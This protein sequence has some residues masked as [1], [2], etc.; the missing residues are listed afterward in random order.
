MCLCARSCVHV[1]DLWCVVV[2]VVEVAAVNARFGG[3]G[4]FASDGADTLRCAGED[5]D[6]CSY[7]MA[8]YEATCDD[9]YC[10]VQ[11]ALSLVVTAGRQYAIHVGGY[12]SDS[13]AYV[14]R[15]SG[16]GSTCAAYATVVRSVEGSF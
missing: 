8:D 1:H 2:V 12:G 5:G 11:S 3:G 14:L 15:A 7:D 6:D 16:P 4:R 9:D 13:G 10:G